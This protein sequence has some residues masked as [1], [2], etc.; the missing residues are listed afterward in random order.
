[1]NKQPIIYAKEDKLYLEVHFWNGNETQSLL[2]FVFLA[3]IDI[4]II[5]VFCL[6]LSNV[7]IIPALGT[8]GIALFFLYLAREEY[9]NATIPMKLIL[10]FENDFIKGPG[11][12]WRQHFILEPLNK[13]EDIFLVQSTEKGKLA[14]LIYTKPTKKL[15]IDSLDFVFRNGKDKSSITYKYIKYAT[16]EEWYDFFK[17]LEALLYSNNNTNVHILPLTP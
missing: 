13:L 12:N 2:S 16:V 5:I 11:I 9:F 4:L 14:E 1:M 7:R 15:A 8:L 3:L 10:D 17:R 6:N